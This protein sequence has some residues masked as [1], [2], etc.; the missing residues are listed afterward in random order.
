MEIGGP[1]DQGRGGPGGWWILDEPE[2]HF[3][4]DV[5]VPDVAGWRRARLPSLPDAAFLSL[6]PNWV[7]EIVS[8]STEQTD[9]LR[10]MRIYARESIPYL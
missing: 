2:T 6:P 1:F 5:L 7:C 8:P 10:K 4:D 9:R 3:G